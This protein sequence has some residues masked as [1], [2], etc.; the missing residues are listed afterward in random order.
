[1]FAISARSTDMNTR[2]VLASSSQILI[3][4][5]RKINGPLSFMFFSGN[6]VTR[7]KDE[8]ERKSTQNSGFQLT[9][10]RNEMSDS[11]HPS[12]NDPP[13][14]YTAEAYQNCLDVGDSWKQVV[15]LDPLNAMSADAFFDAICNT[16]AFFGGEGYWWQDL[17][18]E[19]YLAERRQCI[20]FNLCRFDSVA[21]S[22]KDY[23][24]AIADSMEDAQQLWRNKTRHLTAAEQEDF[25]LVLMTRADR[26]KALHTAEAIR[27]R[28]EVM[29]RDPERQYSDNL[30][31]S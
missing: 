30:W 28:I 18:D 12:D 13:P 27:R 29:E 20:A 19:R 14:I 16:S 5:A 10:R 17:D 22:N 1:M 9:D 25:R 2:V 26:K 4:V 23:L 21:A 11:H 7:L 15:F 31:E 3:K 24:S 6:P 8:A